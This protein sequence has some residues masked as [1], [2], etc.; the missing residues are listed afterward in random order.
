VLLTTALGLWHFG[1]IK[2][3]GTPL[4]AAVRFPA[5]IGQIISTAESSGCSDLIVG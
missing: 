5:H 4:G 3:T 2:C 1:T